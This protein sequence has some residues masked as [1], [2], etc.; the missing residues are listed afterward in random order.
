MKTIKA[1]LDFVTMPFRSKP[2]FFYSVIDHM[3][4]NPDY[5]DPDIPL[6][7]L[8][9]AVDNFAL[10]I[11]AAEDGSH[12]AISARNDSEIAVTLLFKNTVGYVNRV[13]N[14]NLTKILG[15]GF[16][17][18]SQPSPREKAILAITD[19][20]HSGTAKGTT[21]YVNNAGAYTWETR[22]VSSTGVKGPW[23]RIALTTQSTVIFE[24]LE[25]AAI[26]E[27]RVAAITPNGVTDFCAPVAKLVI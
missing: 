2:T 4:G 25:V 16:T 8:K 21:Q 1:L 24:N 22:T 3:T 26:F 5:T 18:S 6:A 13:S 15:S 17:P 27:A 20:P 11:L 10:A 7:T 23:I 12:T 14:G 9:L 19:G